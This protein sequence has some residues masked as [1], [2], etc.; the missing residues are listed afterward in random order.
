MSTRKRKHT[1]RSLLRERREETKRADANLIAYHR[2]HGAASRLTEAVATLTQRVQEAERR[3]E[4]ETA[5]VEDVTRSLR[6]T[7]AEL[8]RL[9]PLVLE[10]SPGDALLAYTAILSAVSFLAGRE[11]TMPD[12][13]QDAARRAEMTNPVFV[14]LARLTLRSPQ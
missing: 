10:L 6:R 8:A 2:E 11:S 12:S 5:A 14:H 7:E 4:E 9:R 1:V 3:L 13:G